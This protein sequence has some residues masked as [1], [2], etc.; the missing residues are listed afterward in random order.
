M[1]PPGIPLFARGASA[2]LICA[3]V[4]FGANPK[5][6]TESWPA[7]WCAPA[8]ADSF[9]YGV[10]HF[11]KA[12]E[13]AAKPAS[14]L[15]HVTADNRYQLFVNGERVVWG[16]ARGDLLHWRY[17]SVDI[18]RHLQAGRNVLA[19]VV[20]ND[21]EYRAV[22]Q[23][24]YRTGLL[25][26]GDGDAE[27]VVNTPRGWTAIQ[28]DAYRPL[29]VSMAM[30]RGYVAI[31]PGEELDATRYPWGWERPDFDASAWR[32]AE[33]HGNG[34]PRG[35]PNSQT[36]WFLVPRS[37]PLME[38]SPI[39]LA[40]VRRM[41]GIAAPDGWLDGR[42]PLE[43]PART[44]ALL[45]LDQNHLTT[46]YPE[47][48]VNGGHGA[49]VQLR[50]AEA[51]WDDAQSKGNR[52]EVD[53]KEFAGYADIY[54][55]DGARHTWRPLYW[56]TWRYLELTVETQDEPLSIEDLRAT[57]TGYPFE[58]KAEFDAG[59]GELDRI[60]DIGWRTARLC[61][62]ETY[63]DCPYYE[64]LQYVGDTRIQALVSLYMSGD[65]R[66]MKNAISQIHDS[67]TADGATYSRAPSALPQYIPPFSLWWI[68]MVHDY[69]L[70][71]GDPEFVG[72]MLPAV[73]GVLAFF[74]RYQQPSA[75]VGLMPWWNYVDWVERW[76]D[77]TPPRG[78]D[79]ATATIDLQLLLAYQWAAELERDLGVRDLSD[80]DRRRAAELR[81]TVQARYWDHARQLYADDRGHRS[82]SQHANALAVLAGVVDGG[83]ATA[84]VERTLGDTTLAPASIYFRYYLN[85]AAAAAGLG[86]QYL[87]LLGPW[88]TMLGQGL[89]TWAE[90]DVRSRSDCHA[91]GSSPNVELLRTVLG[92][93]STAPGFAQVSIAPHP[94][95]LMSVSGAIPHPRGEISVRLERQGGAIDAVVALPAGVEGEFDWQGHRRRLTPGENRLHVRD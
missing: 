82:F 56:R 53:G 30:V 35:A 62:H 66:L 1:C 19:A 28:D 52:D 13:L 68:G 47:M 61:A 48:I 25:V 63:M 71:V 81:K 20:W 78:D 34:A 49:R 41:E 18:S 80:I 83:R 73:R 65:A 70:Y 92:I 91:W 88:R 58:R 16:P 40:R 17:E 85:R 60:L 4:L 50:Y 87:D 32:P 86:D 76:S 12:F 22:A 64:Q 11:R 44:K 39:R 9:G 89:T 42:A 74:H 29:P 7:A 94:G 2:L 93:D 95:T 38:E 54:Q 84:L 21:G 24:S 45:L 59:S 23:V 57:Y 67:Q 33:Y 31:P 5:L 46:G 27:Q 77:G 43:I 6:L 72:E 55:A 10:Y 14:F 26:Q 15:I 37:I 79:G 90:R 51:L 3:P 8:G 75:S 36:P 69:W